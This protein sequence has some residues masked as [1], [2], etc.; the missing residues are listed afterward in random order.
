M[1]TIKVKF[2][3]LNNKAVA[4]W[5]AHPT[6]AGFDLTATSCD[7]FSEKG[8]VTYGTGLAVEIPEGHVGFIF[9]RSSIYKKGLILSNS[10]GVIDC[11]YRGE[12]KLKFSLQRYGAIYNEGDRIGQLVII[13]I[14]SVEFCEVEEL[15][16][17]DRG[18]GG[19]GSSGDW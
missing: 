19:Y 16:N 2:K 6:D 13:P 1:K 8:I 7:C 12:I 9:P 5:Q 17:T 14:P 15:S 4:P 3:K 18:A 10:V 11:H